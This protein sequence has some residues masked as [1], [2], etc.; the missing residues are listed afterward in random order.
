MQFCIAFLHYLGS[1]SAQTQSEIALRNRPYKVTFTLIPSLVL[2]NQT[3]CI[4]RERVT[5]NEA[6][7]IKYSNLIS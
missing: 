1:Q 6:I 4:R 5:Y 7:N 2:H 3:R